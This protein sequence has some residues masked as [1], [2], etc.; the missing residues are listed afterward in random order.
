VDSCLTQKS[1]EAESY[2]LLSLLRVS[3]WWSTDAISCPKKGESILPNQT[4]TDQWN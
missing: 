3:V 2:A 4:W 1:F